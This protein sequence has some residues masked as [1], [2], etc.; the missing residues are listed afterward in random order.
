[1]GIW[2]PAT[3]LILSA[4]VIKRPSRRAKQTNRLTTHGSDVAVGP[5]RTSVRNSR[6][7]ANLPARWVLAAPESRP[8]QS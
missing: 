2:H 1:M 5:D 7:L 8:H 4:C 6:S 3:R